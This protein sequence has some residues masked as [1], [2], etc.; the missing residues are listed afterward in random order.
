VTPLYTERYLVFCLPAVALLAGRALAGLRRRHAAAAVATVL[1]LALPH[2]LAV[3][4]DG[5]HQEDLGRLLAVLRAE[6]RPGDAVVFEQQGTRLL[7]EAFPAT[8]EPLRDVTLGRTGAAAGNLGGTGPAEACR[9]IPARLGGSARVWVVA[10]HGK[11]PDPPAAIALAAMR[12]FAEER[13]WRGR[14]YTLSL[15]VRRAAT[16]D[17]VTC[18]ARP[19]GAVEGQVAAGRRRPPERGR[20]ARCTSRR[21]RRRRSAGS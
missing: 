21:T 17:A 16:D 20:G 13:S 18:P 11:R 10:F 9:T 3:R 14:P 2:Q 8:F 4:A 15:L 1:L 7:A 5:G 6:G 12:G 19:A